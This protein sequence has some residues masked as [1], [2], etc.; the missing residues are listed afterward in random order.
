VGAV[1]AM[2]S[3]PTGLR[4]SSDS[5]TKRKRTFQSTSFSFFIHPFYAE[6]KHGT[7]GLKEIDITNYY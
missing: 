1:I 7:F 4:T 6:K 5:Y 2:Q 3:T